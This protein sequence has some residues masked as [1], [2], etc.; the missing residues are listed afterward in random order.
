[1]TNTVP[2]RVENFGSD[3]T[4]VSSGAKNHSRKFRLA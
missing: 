3:K 1:M 4:P 2:D